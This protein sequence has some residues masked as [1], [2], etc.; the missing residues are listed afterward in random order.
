MITANGIVIEPT[1]FP[2]GTSQVWK[3]DENIFD[4]FPDVRVV[5]DFKSEA[6]FIHL[7]Q[8]KTLIDARR[9]EG[10]LLMPYLPYARQDKGVSNDATFALTTFAE[11]LNSLKFKTVTVVDPH[12]NAAALIKYVYIIYPEYQIQN[13][14]AAC[15]SKFIALPDR[16]AK[17]K[18]VPAFRNMFLSLPIICGSKARDQSTGIITYHP[19]DVDVSFKNV[20]IIDD[21]CDGGMTFVLLAKELKRC[22]ANNVDLFVSHGLF[23][24]GLRVLRGAGI[25]RIFTKYGEIK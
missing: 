8:L 21:I 3:I 25:G 22:G 10:H 12:S 1:I 16:G 14:L 20:M 9:T 18:Y 19:I 4:N 5:W 15:D 2:D 11:L 6:E 24:K 7:A 23:T 17:D 13:A